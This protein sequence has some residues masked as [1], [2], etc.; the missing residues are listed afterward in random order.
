M[1]LHGSEDESLDRAAL[2]Q[3]QRRKVDALLRQV[4]Q[5]NPFYAAKFDGIL[6][7]PLRDPLDVLPLT[8]KAE[9]LRD[10]AQHP[11][12]GTN[13][14]FPIDRYVR[15]HQSS[16]STG[17]APLRW[18][19]TPES[20]HWWKKCWAIVYAGAA[21]TGADRVAFTFS[22][23]PFIGFW[24][25]FDAAAMLSNLCLP[26][27]GMTTAARLRYIIDNRATVVCCTP[28]YAMR[29]ADVAAN[30][31]IDLAPSAVRA[32]IVAGEP[33]GG[34]P[35]VRARIESA[36]GA[37]VYDH[38]GMTEIGAWG[39]QDESDRD[40]ML[41][42]ESEFIAEVIDPVTLDPVPDGQPGELVLTNLG[43]VGS[44]LI[45]YRTGDQ[46]C[47]TRDRQTAGRWFARAEGG[48]LGRVDDMLIIRGNNV[49]PAAIEGV[50]REI[51]E[52]AEYRYATVTDAAMTELKLIIEPRP[53]ADGQAL[54][55]QIDARFRNRFNFRAKIE[56]V[57][58]GSLPRFEMKARRQVDGTTT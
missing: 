30:E 18:L 49:F 44:P 9:I 36:W 22:F 52:V 19:D 14:T 27:G 54:T 50:L 6:L 39:F 21:V 10:Q 24:A 4:R 51:P 15:L 11:P 40:A 43:R 26:A 48:V 12:Y 23:G 17:D 56:L 58:S 8:T 13:L 5:T 33:G 28:T 1:P 37:R 32:L 31:R 7:D 45:R 29:M 53:E 35:A 41:V 2:E 42:I 20:W 38:A 16:G 47:L 46:V 3:F 55:H 34:I 25:A 57:E